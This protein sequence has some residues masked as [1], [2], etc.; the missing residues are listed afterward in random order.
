M[1]EPNLESAQ[2]DTPLPTDAQDDDASDSRKLRPYHARLVA[3]FAQHGSVAE[4]ARVTGISLPTIW[5]WLR[6]PANKTEVEAARSEVHEALTILQGALPDAAKTL[7]RIARDGAKTKEDQISA[8]AAEVTFERF[9]ALR[10]AHL[11]E[12]RIA[13][14]EKRASAVAKGARGDSKR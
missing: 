3:A 2:R 14:L 12:N 11:W 13:Q 5:R 10:K 7:R 4:V 6:N 9:E 1:I 8:K